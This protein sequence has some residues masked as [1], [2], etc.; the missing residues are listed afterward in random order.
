MS[1]SITEVAGSYSLAWAARDVDRIVTLHT[2]DSVFHVHGLGEAASGISAVRQLVVAF[3]VLVPDLQFD[4]RRVYLGA[5]H[6]VSEYVMS[7]T[8]TGS[9]F[10]CDGV[11]VIAVRRGLVARKD[12]YLDL[13]ALQRR[14]GTV[15]MIM[16]S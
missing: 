6:V 4:K 7:G 8:V 14:I 15:P 12:T 11:D 13:A 5:D 16:I 9:D 3:L 10:S 1:A 2:D